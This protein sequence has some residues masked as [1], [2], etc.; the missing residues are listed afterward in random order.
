[1]ADLFAAEFPQ[2][3]VLNLSGLGADPGIKAKPLTFTVMVAGGN[4]ILRSRTM[5]SLRQMPRRAPANWRP[6]RRLSSG[7]LSRTSVCA[8]FGATLVVAIGH[9]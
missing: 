3:Q 2:A 4:V 7:W 9:A 8:A 6:G 1:V 5:R